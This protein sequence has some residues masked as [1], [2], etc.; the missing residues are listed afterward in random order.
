[1]NVPPDGVKYA[2]SAV[3]ELEPRGDGYILID[4]QHNIPIPPTIARRIAAR[5]I[6]GYED[7][8]DDP[9]RL[10]LF[11]GQYLTAMGRREEQ[12]ARLQAL[13]GKGRR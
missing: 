1:M 3:V 7:V 12:A 10:D 6:A 11:H 2:F 13:S 8:E 4:T 9:V 5:I